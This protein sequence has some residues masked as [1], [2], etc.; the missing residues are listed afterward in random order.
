MLLAFWVL[1]PTFTLPCHAYQ[2]NHNIVSFIPHFFKPSF[3]NSSTFLLRNWCPFVSLAPL[4]YSRAGS[5]FLLASISSFA[6]LF[7]IQRLVARNSVV[8]HLG[9]CHFSAYL[10]G[11]FHLGL[12]YILPFG[13][14]S[15]FYYSFYACFIIL[16]FLSWVC[17]SVWGFCNAAQI[18]V[19]LLIL[20]WGLLKFSAQ[21]ITSIFCTWPSLFNHYFTCT[22][23]FQF[24]ETMSNSNFV[25][26][27][28]DDE[29]GESN[30]A[31]PTPIS[32][33]F[34]KA[35]NYKIAQRQGHKATNKSKSSY[36]LYY[37]IHFVFSLLTLTLP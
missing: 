10:L 31:C 14:V 35:G 23:I 8:F 7:S 26:L 30:S 36:Y 15:L 29:T 32:R 27:S 6:A 11:F 22:L 3:T 2:I 17:V 24:A 16:C 4:V 1:Q 33:Q 20:V 25:D 19:S 37:I 12:Y 13:F 34:W 5:F 9:Y 18:E 28:G 21:H